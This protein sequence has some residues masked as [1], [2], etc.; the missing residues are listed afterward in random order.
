VPRSMWKIL[1][2]LLLSG[3]AFSSSAQTA[4]PKRS[5]ATQ[6]PP[7]GQTF[8]DCAECPEMVV[9]PS[10]SFTMGSPASEPGRFDIEGP[11]HT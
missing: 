11:Q 5:S 6:V 7:P 9:I 1:A 4:D 10:G 2:P 8:R 3:F